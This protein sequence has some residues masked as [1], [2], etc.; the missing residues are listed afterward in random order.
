MALVRGQPDVQQFDGQ[1]G[2]TQHRGR[3]PGEVGRGAA[4][5]EARVGDRQ[6]ER[7]REQ[8]EQDLGGAAVSRGGAVSAAI[9]NVA[10][11]YWS[12]TRSGAAAA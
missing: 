5:E 10:S 3:E 2:A 7:R 4:V 6:V 9:D 8:L 1:V 11:Q 12:R